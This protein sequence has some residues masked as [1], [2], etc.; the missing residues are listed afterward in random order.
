MTTFPE[1]G[2]S[3]GVF[4]RLRGRFR[5]FDT[6]CRALSVRNRP[7]N[8]PSIQPAL[9]PSTRFASERASAY[10]GGVFGSTKKCQ[11]NLVEQVQFSGSG[12]GLS[13]IVDAQLAI[14]SARV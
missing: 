12:C 9:R 14:N 13:T 4:L 7:K 2:Y 8:D 1:W 3:R 11:Q 6:P 5:H 10:S